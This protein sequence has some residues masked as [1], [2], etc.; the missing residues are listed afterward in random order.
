MQSPSKIRALLELSQNG[1]IRARDLAQ[2]K[3]PRAYLTRLCDRGVLERVDRGIYRRIDAA[4]TEVHSLAQASL[5]IPK[6]T[7]CLLSA[8][9]FHELTT[10]LP[11][12]IWM[13]IDRHARIPGPTQ[14]RLEIVRASGYARDHGVEEHEIEGVLVKITSPAKTVADCFCYRKY[15]GLDVAMASLR[16][17]VEKNVASIDELVAAAKADRVYSLMRPYVE[18]LV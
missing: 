10:E 14:Q 12:A 7:I 11:Y 17:Y 18:I 15:V 13:M 4:L 1:P 2:A 3:T 8:L 9:Q 6:G 5:R 16:E